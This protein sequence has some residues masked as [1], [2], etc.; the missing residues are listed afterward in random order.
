MKPWRHSARVQWWLTALVVGGFF[1]ATSVAY[2]ARNGSP[3]GPARVVLPDGHH[4][5][6]PSKSLGRSDDPT[7]R[8]AIVLPFT[9]AEVGHQLDSLELWVETG[10][11]SH[12]ST[13]PYTD[14]IFYYNR[15][16]RNASD[17]DPLFRSPRFL[18]SWA[19]LS[20]SFGSYSVHYADLDPSIDIYPAGPSHMCVLDAIQSRVAE[21]ATRRFFSL[22][23]TPAGRAATAPYKAI[24]WSEWDTSPIRAGWATK[25]YE[26]ATIGEP[27][28]IKG[29]I[30][31]GRTLDESV[32]APSNWDWVSHINGNALY[33][34]DDPAFPAF[35]ETVVDQEPPSHYWKPFDISIAKVFHSLPYSWQWQQRYAGRFQYAS[36]IRHLGFTISEDQLDAARADPK[37]FLVH[38]KRG[39]AGVVKYEQKFHAGVPTAK[40]EIEWTDRVPKSMRMSVRRDSEMAFKSVRLTVRIRTGPPSHLPRR[41]RIRS[42]RGRVGRSQHP[43][44]A[45]DSHRGPDPGP[46]PLQNKDLAGR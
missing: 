19:S 27:F 33:A 25:L 28:F 21:P 9:E 1:E 44:R 3:L 37:C 42:R 45:R 15:G 24:F 36:F 6:V 35:L 43:Q 32:A 38:G 14:L 40:D 46:R 7:P 26:E 23:L 2:R 10:A 18:K 11:P 34:T 16:P 5:L 31:H 8:I 17:L 12:P 20:S 22:F 13:A 29:S 4:V 41:P 39:S 30:Y